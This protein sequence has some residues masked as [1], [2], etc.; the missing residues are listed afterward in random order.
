VNDERLRK[1]LRDAELPD[2]AGARVR[3][4]RVVRAAY[5]GRAAAPP[6]ERRRGRFAL[7][8][9]AAAAVLA[10]VL[11]PAGAKV[12]DVFRD[13]TGIS[14]EKAKP[15][16]S[17][18]PASGRLLVGSGRGPW[19]VRHDGSN[20]LL[21]RYSEATWS[22]HGLFVAATGDHELAAIDP[23]NGVVHWTIARG[24]PSDPAWSPSGFRIA[25]RAGNELRLVTGAGNDDHL[26]AGRSAD[27]V[28]AWRPLSRIGRLMVEKQVEP[29]E[30]L[31]YAD[32]AGRVKVLDTRSGRLIWTSPSGPLPRALLWTP[33]G[34]RLIAVGRRSVRLY[35]ARGTLARTV[36]LPA[37]TR[38]SAAA[39]APAGGILAVAVDQRASGRLPHSRVE[40]LDLDRPTS[41]PRTVVSDPGRFTG[42]AFSPNG[43]W[44]LVA[45]RDADQWL[46]VPLSGGKVKAVAHIS[47]QFA[48]GATRAPAFPSLDGWCCSG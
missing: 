42:V 38:A 19:V 37:G 15:A 2:E 13:V 35:S 27:V 33:D 47:E 23:K 41:P 6:R 11:T 32:S 34:R 28:P 44:L 26:L 16:L 10:I 25:Y 46:F 20:R 43:R 7:A 31:A 48:P 21:G 18:L 4:W 36:P 5:A 22:A 14:S 9:A 30:Q 3:G 8:L 40:L 29:P 12:A 24:R 45:W 17:S 1:L 39:I